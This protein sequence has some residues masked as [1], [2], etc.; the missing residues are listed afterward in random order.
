M[1][2]VA[3]HTNHHAT[4]AF[5][6]LLFPLFTGEW[7]RETRRLIR[8]QVRA[9]KGKVG[10]EAKRVIRQDERKRAN[11]KSRKKMEGGD[12]RRRG[13]QIFEDKERQDTNAK[14]REIID[15][16]K[17]T[18]RGESSAWKSS[19]SVIFNGREEWRGAK[20]EGKNESKGR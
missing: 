16:R 8:R 15:K 5:I 12:G 13:R 17:I 9:G 4:E 1:G 6:N 3:R 20:R 18:T 11:M 19:S 7:A 2:F 14:E 10:A